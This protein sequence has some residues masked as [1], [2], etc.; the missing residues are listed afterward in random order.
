MTLLETIS[1]GLIFLILFHHIIYPGAMAALSFL[2]YRKKDSEA[3][4]EERFLSVHVVIPACNEEKHIYQ[5]LKSIAVALPIEGQLVVTVLDDGSQDNTASEVMRAKLDFADCDIHLIKGTRN[6]GKVKRINQLL[7]KITETVTV[8]TD[9]SAILK[10]E[11]LI[12]A[13][14]HF[15][16]KKIGVVSGGYTLSIAAPF[17]QRLYWKIQALVKLGEN[18]LGTLIGAHGAFYAIRTSLYRPLPE[19]T[20]N[21]DFIIPMQIAL[22]GWRVIYDPSM[23]TI[24]AQVDTLQQDFSRRHR[25]G[26]G[27]I[28]QVLILWPLVASR[29]FSSASLCLIAGKFLRLLIGPSLITLAVILPIVTLMSDFRAGFIG[30]FVG[31]IILTITAVR[32]SNRLISA[33]TQTFG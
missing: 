17:A 8:L 29:I 3:L 19:D 13:V 15:K 4:I 14:D 22:K 21:D 27:N 33:L 24:E 16:N 6:L 1:L 23:Q 20:I 31:A 7:P 9:S 18:R 10:K 32:S 28:Q 11:A 30:L 12:T 26:A 2:P 5:K 25:I